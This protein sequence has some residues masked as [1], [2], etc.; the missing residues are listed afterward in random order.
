[1]GRKALAIDPYIEKLEQ[2]MALG[3]T[4]DMAAMYAGISQRTF[5]RWRAQAATAPEGSPFGQLRERLRQAEG[6]AAIGWLAKIEQ[7]ASN[8]DFRAAAWKLERRYP[9][10]FGRQMVEHTGQP[11]GPIEFV[12][13]VVYANE[14]SD[15]A[16]GRGAHSSQIPAPAATPFLIQPGEA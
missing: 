13:K 7:A 14:H 5:E 2:A 11:V 4:Y 10:V 6:R 16:P 3:A 1:M 15:T 8:G 9:E 12:L